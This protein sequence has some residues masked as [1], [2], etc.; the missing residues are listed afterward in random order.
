MNDWDDDEIALAEPRPTQYDSRERVI[1]T[2][3]GLAVG[4]LVAYVVFSLLLTTQAPGWALIFFIY[5][6]IP[7]A[8]IG[9]GVGAVLGWA[10][11]RVGNQWFHVAAFFAAG[12]LI[13]V[14]FGGFSSWGAT[15]FSLSIALAAGMGRLS[16]WKLVKLNPQPSLT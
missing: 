11:R 16:V 9:S 2:G 5:A 13:C 8:F 12:A 1:L 6:A 15:L 4:V 7:S 3:K 10:L 14:P